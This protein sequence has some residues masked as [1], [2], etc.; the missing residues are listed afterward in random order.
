[1]V[2]ATDN[3]GV[4]ALR[5]SPAEHL[6]TDFAVGSVAGERGV[7]LREVPFQTMVG[8]RV[9]PLSDVG[10]RIAAVT[11]GLPATCG[12]VSPGPAGAATVWLGPDEF[13]VIAPEEGGAGLAAAL[14]AALG[15]GAGQAVE[16]S[17]NRTTFELSGPSARAV[18]EKSCAADLHPRSF[19]AGTAITTEIGKIPTI[20]W[21]TGPETFRLFPRAS[22]AD[23]LGRWLLD[24]MREFATAELPSWR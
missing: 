3:T 10:R 12:A 22:F 23:Y 15:D 14:V 2:N 16:L 13:L 17:S 1:M 18:L 11:G 19:A 20:L 6:W 7:G 5:R 9:D 24:G 21:R 8:L 4:R